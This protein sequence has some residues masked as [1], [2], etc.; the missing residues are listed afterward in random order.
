MKKSVKF[1]NVLFPIW[2]L[3]IFPATWLVVLPAN[4]IIDSV[5]LVLTARHLKIENIKHVY[6][7][8][9][10]RIWLLGFIADIAGGLPL[11]L[12]R[13]DLG[14]FWYKHITLPLTENP[15]SDPIG[16]VYCI[17]CIAISGV[18][19]YIFDLK[20]ALRNTGLDEKKK[21]TLA[22]LMAVFTAPYIYAIPSMFIY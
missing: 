8:S 12:S 10:L 6:K 16:L 20:G 11:L 4:F 14:D 3:L 7:K 17:L 1:F 21:K 2:L 9:I 18:L 22:V 13:A 19:I 5:V 15:F